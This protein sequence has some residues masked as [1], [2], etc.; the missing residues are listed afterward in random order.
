MFHVYRSQSQLV[1]DTIDEV[2]EK[3]L[4]DVATPVLRILGFIEADANSRIIHY[5]VHLDRIRQAVNAYK[6]GV[7]SLI[8][9]LR[10]SVKATLEL[11]LKSLEPVLKSL[12][13]VLKSPL[14]HKN[15]FQCSL[16]PVLMFFRA[17]SKVKRGRKPKPEEQREAQSESIENKRESIEIDTGESKEN[18]SVTVVTDE[19]PF[20][21]YIEGHA[22]CTETNRQRYPHRVSTMLRLSLI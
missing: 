21:P 8:T 22:M 5:T 11:V 19:A 12:E 13:L 15:Q 6:Q 20:R 14:Q 16:E 1:S 17:S 7:T 3:T 2:C 4:C 10:Q 18:I 9:L